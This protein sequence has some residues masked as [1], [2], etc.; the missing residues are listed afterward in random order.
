MVQLVKI[1]KDFLVGFFA[2]MALSDFVLKKFKYVDVLAY[3]D[4][5]TAKIEYVIR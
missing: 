1:G 3:S 5:R 2:V 4:H